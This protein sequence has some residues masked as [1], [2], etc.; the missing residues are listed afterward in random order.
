MVNK[1]YQKLQTSATRHES[2]DRPV[3]AEHE[4]SERPQRGQSVDLLQLVVIQ[5]EEDE[6]TQ[7]VHVLHVTDGVVLEVQQTQLVLRLER[8]TRRQTA[9]RP[10][11]TARRGLVLQT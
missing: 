3:F 7:V 10:H 1:D 9:P 4:Y 6:A 8:G 5:V 2:W 11:H